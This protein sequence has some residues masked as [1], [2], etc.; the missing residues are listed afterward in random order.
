[1]QLSLSWFEVLLFIGVIQG[2]LTCLLIWFSRH[3]NRSSLWLSMVLL[4]FSLLCI[5]LLILTTGAWNTSLLRYFPLPVELAIAPLFWL[6][7]RS[8]AAQLF[9]L[10]GRILL[11]FLP[12]DYRHWLETNISN[13][14]NPTYQWIRNLSFLIGFPFGFTATGR[15]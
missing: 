8:L 9:Q 12:F 14:D 3:R 5:R 10:R 4:V 15:Y 6:Y 11:Y 13:T 1:M 7:I 2:L